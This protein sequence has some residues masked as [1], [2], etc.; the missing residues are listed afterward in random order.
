MDIEFLGKIFTR[1]MYS[2]ITLFFH[3]I[4]YNTFV[5]F[6]FCLHEDIFDGGWLVIAFYF[7]WQY[8]ELFFE[9]TRN[10][11]TEDNM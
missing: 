4:A 1:M 11:P 5:M 3:S 2:C 6:E 10:P 8:F 9:G 7:L